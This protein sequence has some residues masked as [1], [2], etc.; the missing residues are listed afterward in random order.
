MNLRYLSTKASL[1][2]PH[3]VNHRVD[4]Q[5]CVP[6]LL[7]LREQAQPMAAVCPSS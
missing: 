5:R 6:K 3:G 4:D 2:D 1:V 7:A